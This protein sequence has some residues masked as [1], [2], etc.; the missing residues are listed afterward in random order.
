MIAAQEGVDNSYISRMMNLTVLAPDILEAIL[1]DALVSLTW[2][3]VF[4]HGVFDLLCLA[5]EIQ[6]NYRL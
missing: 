3:S 5:R 6:L 4:D 1:D 2:R